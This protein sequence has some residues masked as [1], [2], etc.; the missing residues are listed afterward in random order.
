MKFF[1]IPLLLCATLASAQSLPHPLPDHPGNIFLSDEDVSLPLASAI[2]GGWRVVDYD[3]KELRSGDSVE[4][5]LELGKLPVGYYDLRN[6]E[7][8]VT[9]LGVVAPL[10]SPTP[11][12][13]PISIDVAMAWFYSTEARQRAAANL[14]NLA[15]INWV[16]DRLSWG[17]MEPQKG[18]FAPHNIYDDTAKLQTEIELKILQVNHN[19]PPW[20][21]PDGRRMPLDLRDA[22]NFY[23]AMAKRWQG[24]VLAFE[25][26]NEAD[27]SV[28]GGH[29]GAEM[30]SMQ[31]ASY[32]GL[33][34][35]NPDV[36]AC[37]N[38][39]AIDRH[40]TLDDF[41]ANDVSP[42][43][44][45][46]NLHHYVGVERY[47]AFYAA[48]RAVSGGKPMWVTECNV[49]VQWS[50]DEKLKEPS[51]ADLRVQARRV[52]RIFAAS[53]YEGSTNTFYF[54]LP[55][56]VEGKLQYGALHED[57]TPRPAYLALAAVGRLL[58][59]AKPM[60]RWKC[61]DPDVRAFLFRAKPDGEEKGVL[62]AWNIKG[63]G[64]VRLD[65]P[66]ERVL[67]HLGRD[68]QRGT[69]IGQL[70]LSASPVFAVMPLAISKNLKLDPPP[71]P[72]EKKEGKV[73]PVVLQLL[74]DPA[75]I[76]LKRS[77][78]VLAPE[79][80]HELSVYA[81]N[82]SDNPADGALLISAP[83]GWTVQF[84]QQ[85]RIEPR[86]RTELKLKLSPRPASPQIATVKF[87][88]TFIDAENAVLSFRVADQQ[89]TTQPATKP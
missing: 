33:K 72:P 16:R 52:A 5:K 7:K 78:Y 10:K 62:V 87:T 18:Q 43:F 8:R 55:H 64:D 13:S 48:H 68:T 22:Y 58:A 74:M 53:L 46:Y 50:G 38:V 3:G 69:W 73:S 81:Y 65:A 35:G 45:T 59:G 17:A 51:D 14:C 79:K 25:P 9:T 32:L 23:R 26:W 82:F 84:P 66:V 1:A 11:S 54:M 63:E 24:E 21:N 75:T 83:R 41:G 6:G 27:I 80:S 2:K 60:G 61:D 34:A 12:D 40:E 37:E 56:Y 30:A 76:D 42:Y 67:D 70:H 28:F 77:A 20:A 4:N 15:G 19:S 49:T 36:I 88:S 39:F 47:P 86:G 89:S 85:V 57:L 31:K 71:S 44:D 29:T